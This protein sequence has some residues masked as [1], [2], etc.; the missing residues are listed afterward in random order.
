MGPVV[1]GLVKIGSQ[2]VRSEEVRIVTGL[3]PVEP[4]KCIWT[5]PLVVRKSEAGMLKIN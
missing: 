4:V 3:T 2:F 1:G 5:A